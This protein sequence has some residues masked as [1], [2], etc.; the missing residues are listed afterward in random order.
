LGR[1]NFRKIPDAIRIKAAGLGTASVVVGALREIPRVDV[2]AG[3]WAHLDIRL[4]G[5][6]VLVPESAVPPASRGRFSRA[7]R[8]GM[9][10]VR[11][12]LPKIKKTFSVETPN[13][14]DWSR[15]SHDMSWTREVYQKEFFPPN[16]L[17]IVMETVS[18]A[19][20]AVRV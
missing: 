11:R 12:D 2:E 16:G 18:Q 13:W 14:G 17:S 10:V 5:G 6:E 19:P 1:K 9:D 15:G 4:D 8:E 20:D 3:V 7:N